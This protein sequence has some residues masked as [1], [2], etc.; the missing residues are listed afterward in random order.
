MR[1]RTIFMA[2]LLLCDAAAA[3]S[4]RCSQWIVSEDVS[5]EKLLQKWGEPTQKTSETFDVYG[6]TTSGGRN[7]RGTTTI[8]KWTYD[9]GSQAF[10]MVVTIVDGK[11]KSMERGE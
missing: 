3:E 5:V 11:I 2:S 9:R 8:E 1:A 7:K 10:P 6:P 4:F